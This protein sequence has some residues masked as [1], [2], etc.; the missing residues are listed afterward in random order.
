MLISA[1]NRYNVSEAHEPQ[2]L[3]HEAGYDAFM[4]GCLFLR[5]NS[6]GFLHHIP[7]QAARMAE[8]TDSH[9]PVAPAVGS[10]PALSASSLPQ[11][12]SPVVEAI[13]PAAPQPCPEVE[14]VSAHDLLKAAGLFSNRIAMNSLSFPFVLGHAPQRMLLIVLLPSDGLSFFLLAD[15][16][17]EAKAQKTLSSRLSLAILFAPLLLAMIDHQPM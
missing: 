3:A 4:T 12:P 11:L 17:A 2:N 16:N 13:Q 5:L 10:A 15:Y 9:T 6:G 14:I 7:S 1:C 8:M